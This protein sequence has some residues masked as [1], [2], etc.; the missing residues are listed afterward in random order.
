MTAFRYQGSELELFAGA[1]NWKRYLGAQ[2]R[3]FLGRDVLEVGAGFGGTTS[4]LCANQRR[5]VCLEPDAAMAE[6]ISEAI[7]RGALPACCE[8]V[9][10]TLPTLPTGDSFDTILYCDVL[11]HIEDDR[12]ELQHAAKRLAVGGHLVVLSPAHQWLYTP[13]DAH[14]GHYRRYTAKGLE[15]LSPPGLRVVASRYLDSVGLLASLGNRMLLQRSMPTIAQ[16]EF[17][18]R[19]LVRSSVL[20]DRVLAYRIGKSVLVVWRRE[21]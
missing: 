15:A 12:G 5:W 2:I 20:L 17:W 11:E 9:S 1:S 6:R 14:I 8:S 7:G 3:P 21:Q 16:I 10:A 19:A 4:F 18:D 13:F